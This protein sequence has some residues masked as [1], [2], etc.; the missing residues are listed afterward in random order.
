MRLFN[1][2]G[3]PTSLGRCNKRASIGRVAVDGTGRFRQISR[4]GGVDG[5]S[6]GGDDDRLRKKFFAPDAETG[7]SSS[8]SER[9]SAQ[10]LPDDVTPS[11]DAV[12]PIALG[13]QAR[14]AFDEV[15][16]QL[17]AL[18]SP[19]KSFSLEDEMGMGYLVPMQASD[20]FTAPQVWD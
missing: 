1:S 14:R 4:A 12:N 20:N 11:L 2:A 17:S 9:G 7:P 10:S 19:T 13:R 15:W 18:A 3:H 8:P 16:S 6:S 5:P